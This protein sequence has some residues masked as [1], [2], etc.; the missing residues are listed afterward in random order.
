MIWAAGI[1]AAACLGAVVWH[2]LDARF[3]ETRVSVARFLP[4]LPPTSAPRYRFRLT[5]LVTSARFWL[6]M[7][8]LLL[9]LLAIL[10]DLITLGSRQ[11]DRVGLSIVV[12][13][14]DSM[15]ATDASGESR[16]ALART[17]LDAV[18]AAGRA[19][20]GDRPFCHALTG[21]GQQALALASP[22]DVVPRPEAAL[23]A[24]LHLAAGRLDPPG[25]PITHGIVIS[26]LPP[27]VTAGDSARPVIWYQLG[28]PAPNTAIL[29]ARLNGAGLGAA[30]GSLVIALSDP[31]GTADLTVAGPGGAVPVTLRQDL[32]DPSRR[33]ATL[34][35]PVPGRYLLQLTGAAGD[36]YDG[37]NRA[38]LDLPDRVAPRIDWHLSVLPRPA[39][40]DQSADGS[41][42][43]VA[44]LSAGAPDRPALLLAPAAAEG[45]GQIGYFQETDPMMESLNLDVFERLALPVVDLPDGFFPILAD[46]SGQVWV[47]RR[48]EPPALLVPALALGGDADRRNTTLLLFFNALGDLVDLPEARLPLV[49]ERPDGTPVP[50]ADLEG[51]TDRPLSPPPD[52]SLLATAPAAA[53]PLP[54]YPWLIAAALLLLL[55]ERAWAL[56]WIRSPKGDTSR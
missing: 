11:S 39:G 18:I 24:A 37:D 20:A 46:Q 32:R 30:A 3:T 17:A 26:D 38:R 33:L 14:S 16:A 13:L 45:G 55:L 52:L 15:R 51:A 8:I 27:P 23:P 5:R 40:L 50:A 48:L 56:N 35:N 1:A 29:S 43:L 44:D 25:C 54:A 21:L 47:A 34:V 36:A 22:D 31:T 42:L 6:R 53:E 7:L 19:A 2:M 49:W 12:D 4:D 28:A 9:L 41:A 10:P